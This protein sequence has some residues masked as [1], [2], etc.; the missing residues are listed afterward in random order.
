M[1]ASVFV[2]VGLVRGG[3]DANRAAVDRVSEDEIDDALRRS[4]Q[5][6]S[7]EVDVEA[8][9]EAELVPSAG[10]HVLMWPPTALLGT[11]AA[12][13]PAMS[14]TLRAGAAVGGSQAKT[15]G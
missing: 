10:Q 14:R 13:D 6:P 2:G 5:R 12:V 7:G 8:A 11:A 15:S 9:N 4:V 3:E 1:I